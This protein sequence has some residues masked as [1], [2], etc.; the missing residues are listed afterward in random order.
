YSMLWL[1][2]VL[3]AFQMMFSAIFEPAKTSS[4][5]NVTTPQEL[6]DANVLSSASWSIIFTIG[7]G[8]GGLATAWVGTDFVFVDNTL[9]YMLSGLLMFD[10]IIPQKKMDAKE[11]KRTRKPLVR[12]REGLQYLREHR[13]I[14][15]PTLAKACYTMF[16]RALT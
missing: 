15:R 1:A 3:T 12:I 6:V 10:T 7:M 4:I 11:F 13:Q 5:P 16:L 2:Y 8:I 14:L 9:S